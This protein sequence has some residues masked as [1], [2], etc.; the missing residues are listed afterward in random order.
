MA[1]I[2]AVIWDCDKTL[3]DG[4]MQDPMF[5]EYGVDPKAFWQETD[6][7]P[8]KYLR[9]QN[10]RVNPDT[11]YL[12]QFIRYAR[13]GRFPGLN[14][15][16]LREFGKKQKFYPGIPE[17]FRSTEKLINDDPAYAE[18]G[19]RLEHY[20]ISTGFSE[21]I[22]GS[23][24]MDYMKY[25]WGCELIEDEDAEG[26]RLISEIGYTIDNTTK[27]RAL[28][29]INKGIP[30]DK[31][32]SVNS[33]IPEENR[34]VHMNNMIYIADGPSDIPAFSVVRKGGG[35]TFAIYPKGDARAM[36]QV[37]ERRDAG[38]VDMYAEADYSEGSTA[39]MWIM[40]KIK[41]IADRIRHDEQ[42][43]IRSSVSGIPQHL[44]V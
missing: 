32:I 20:I 18:Y 5:E 22:R 28:F 15:E 34:R 16:R 42:H 7:L 10:V 44:N 2:I 36:A 13:D 4:Y 24:L 35:A 1:N 8:E 21:V 29:E 38:R 3:I 31:G 27:T 26:R 25:I 9:E 37:E 14:N 41:K 12:N 6:A 33:S 40:G 30:F 11:I 17:I 23:I 39:Y 19:I 43:K